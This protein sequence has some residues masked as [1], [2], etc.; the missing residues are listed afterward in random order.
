MEVW[1]GGNSPD[2]QMQV[3]QMRDS[4]MATS[5]VTLSLC[6]S[7]LSDCKCILQAA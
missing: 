6:L 5:K 1:R 2:M 3:I 4:D 7:F